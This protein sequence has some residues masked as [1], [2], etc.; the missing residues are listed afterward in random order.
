[1]VCSGDPEPLRQLLAP[2]A[3]PRGLGYPSA[4]L[5]RGSIATGGQRKR[6][7]F[8]EY[9]STCLVIQTLSKTGHFI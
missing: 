8:Y 1:M 7:R 5:W 9:Q 2:V 3:L 6:S 4:A